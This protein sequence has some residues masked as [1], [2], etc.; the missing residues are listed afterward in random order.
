V[1]ENVEHAFR[2]YWGDVLAFLRVRTRDEHR[3]EE[4]AQQVFAEAAAGL[5]DD[6][7]EPLGWLYTV[8]RRRFADEARRQAVAG[9]LRLPARPASYDSHIRAALLDVFEHLPETQRRVVLL[10]LVRGL[11]FAEVASRLDISEEAAR[12]RFSRALR[13]LRT[14]LEERGVEP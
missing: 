12:M 11:P 6:G 14:S 3:A 4:L 9:R 2:A 1:T 8:A 7:R 13:Q 5:E 10:K